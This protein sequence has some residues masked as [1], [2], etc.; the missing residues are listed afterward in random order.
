MKNH[1]FVLLISTLLLFSCTQKIKIGNNSID[2]SNKNRR[3]EVLFLGNKS[4]HHD[5]GKYAPWLAV[6]LFKEGINVTYTDNIDD[7]NS[8]NLLK[9]D[10]LIIYANYETI[11]VDQETALKGFVEGGKGLIALHSASGCFKNSE[12]Y[13][14]TIG[15]QF[16][17]HSSGPI[18]SIINKS[19]HQI[20]KDLASFIT[21]WD[22]TY[23]HKN[24]NS[25]M[26]V[27]TSRKDVKGDIPYTWIR[28]QG[29]G[30]V[31]YTAYGHNDSTWTNPGFLKLV[32]NGVKWSLGNSVQNKISNLNIPKVDIY[33]SSGIQISDF[34]KRHMV[35]KM[36]ESL[37]P[38][39][40]LKLSQVPVDFDIKLFA[41][42]PDIT[43]PIAMAWDERGRLWIVESVD[44]PNTFLETD[45]ASND[46]IKI[47]E[48]MDGDGKADKFTIFAD[49][50]N[51]PTSIVFANGGLVVSMA[52]YF[53]F[54]KDTDGDDRADV[55]EIIMKGWDKNDT[56]FGP[57]NLQYGFNN[58]IWG[59]VGSGFT[60]L[61]KDGKEYNFRTGVYNLNPDGTGLNFLG[62]TSNNTWGLGITEEN[63]VFISTANNTHSAYYSMPASLLQRN[64]LGSKIQS[65]Q[66]IDGHY[67]SHSLTP[68][69]RQV[70]VV[71]GFT[72]AAGH[73]FY[74]ARDF[75]KSY[76]NRIAFVCEPTVRLIHNAIIN[77]SGSGFSENDG[78]N[79]LASSDE[80][81]GPVQAEVGPDGAV[82]VADWYN[83]IIQHN[84]FVERQ[85]P[86]NMVLPFVNQPRGQGNAFISPMRDINHGRI[87]R[88]VYKKAKPYS[89][90][91]LSKN[92]PIS[93]LKGL[94]SDNM[95]WRM[96]AQRL[97]VESKNISLI[98]ELY[99]IIENNQ[100]DEIGLNSPAV[101][102]IWTLHGLGEIN[103][104]NAKSLNAISLALKHP[105]AGVRKAAL[106]TLPPSSNS[107]ELILNSG[108]LNDK[109]LNV[110]LAAFISIANM[111]A[112][113]NVG[114]E[115]YKQSLMTD[116]ESDE[117]I[118]QALFAA[119]IINRDGF[120]LAANNNNIAQKDKNSLA[121]KVFEGINKETYTLLRRST[122][123]LIPDVTN[124]ELIIRGK[125]IKGVR[126]NE[127]LI[128]GQGGNED[129]YGL[130]IKDNRLC[131]SI[132]QYNQV[133]NF[134]SKD[135]LKDQF[136]FTF[137]LIKEGLVELSVDD[138]L[139]V[140]GKVPALFSRSLLKEVQI[141]R[142]QNTSNVINGNSIESY[143]TTSPF[144]G[145]LLN[146]TL[147]LINNPDK[148]ISTPL[149]QAPTNQTAIIE[150]KV[151]PEQMKYDKQ[152]VTVKSGAP[153]IIKLDNP[154]NMQHNLII[155]KIGTKEKVGNAADIMAKDP[156]AFEKNYIPKMDEI[157]AST[158]LV[159]PGESYFLEFI[160]PKIPGDYPFIC[161]F[162]GHW[163]IMQ[164]ILR[165]Q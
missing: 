90:L 87:Y 103:P 106:E 130:Y 123:S 24:L 12:W 69:L 82:W 64:L 37:K 32:N 51:I 75:P 26:T 18:E 92:D 73:H 74:T 86:S 122:I 4:K 70:D 111:P 61:S 96:T 41:S 145:T 112:S 129:G 117:W 126:N 52:P 140:K 138:D 25:D 53:L 15:G 152:I 71:G 9:Y 17:S 54:L 142:V 159:N 150:I 110:R 47:C 107:T 105:A 34:T 29:K 33:E 137:K 156:K 134:V 89:P 77:P 127:G 30:R 13:I 31:F 118:P 59:V 56:H 48:D 93:L 146:G 136:N 135:T 36:Q 88:I 62:N 131:A 40:S 120:L 3:G 132:K 60:G 67:D 1:F 164:G 10:G 58:K 78:W 39:E 16:A 81:V 11:S 83:F 76:W 68:N 114:E 144:N 133:Y 158:K 84:V 79:L 5:S 14:K 85:A 28:N 45:G 19:D 119:A 65:V 128:V 151:I 124:K 27:L 155:C 125:I 115:I 113:K 139:K 160:A 109:N 46:R 100:L 98:P 35:P 63:N 94:N 141:Q 149:P 42:E 157:I 6:S 91:T 72:S 143:T 161:T 80:W 121:Y 162:P 49:K 97:I 163:R 116:N 154:D 2:T 20:T 23:M 8:E 66:K 165:V 43:N 21:K 102:A 57:S 38:E 55:R 108:I 101:H 153:V 104:N 99:K 44:Y 147:E 7:L 22:E 50:L 95:F 148:N